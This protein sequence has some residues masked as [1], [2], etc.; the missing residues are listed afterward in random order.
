MGSNLSKNIVIALALAGALGLVVT[1]RVIPYLVDQ[2]SYTDGDQVWHTTRGEGLRYAVW[3]PAE[4]LGE[5]VNTPA[6]ETRPALSGDGRWLV[7]G[8]G[9]QGQNAELYVARMVDGQ[10][11]DAR[12]VAGLNSD[13]DEIAP[14]FGGD[15]LYFASNRPGG[16]GGFDLY[17]A[18]W[19]GERFGPAR[20]L[21][22]SV[23]TASDE[24]DPALHGTW[25]SGGLG[26]TGE[27]L[28]ASNRAGA[29]R[30]DF[31]LF[32]AS[33]D[34]LEGRVIV[35]A[36]T[37]LN[38]PGEEREPGLTA[39]GRTLFF[40]S[41]RDEAGNFDLWKSFR[42]QGTWLA[43]QPL[44]GLNS[45]ASERGPGPSADGFALFF[46]RAAGDAPPDLLRAESAEL[47]RLPARPLGW[48]DLA[49]LAALLLL[50]L[51]AWLS[52]RWE[53]LDI[54]YKCFLVSLLVHLLLMWLMRG[55]HPESEPQALSPG[56]APTFKVRVL[57]DTTT[58]SARRERG[59]ALESARE[60]VE[61]AQAPARQELEQQAPARPTLRRESLA[62]SSAELAQG[63]AAAPLR[64]ARAAASEQ[65]PVPLLAD[66]GPALPLRSG[67]APALEVAVDR[68][69]RTSVAP[70]GAPQQASPS[71]SS[72]VAPEVANPHTP[73]PTSVARV[74]SRE[75]RIT[76]PEPGAPGTAGAVAALHP[77]AS[78]QRGPS[79]AQP[80]AQPGEVAA[81][82]SVGE[83]AASLPEPGSFRGRVEHDRAVAP[84]LA[85]PSADSALR[86]SSEALPTPGAAGLVAQRGASESPAAPSFRPTRQA[87]ARRTSGV[88]GPRLEAPAAAR[89]ARATSAPARALDLPTPTGFE[90]PMR[91]GR[92]RAD[93][94]RADR[95]RTGP[96]GDA[97][98]SR[99]S[100]PLR[101]S[102]ASAA[103][104]ERVPDQPRPSQVALEV[105][106]PPREVALP[107]SPRPLE[108]TPYRS[109]FGSEKQVALETFGGGVDTERAVLEGLKYLAAHQR[110]AGHWASARDRDAKYH[111][112][113]VG[114]TALCLLAFLAAGHTPDSDTQFSGTARRA[115]DY[116]LGTQLRRNGHFGDTASYGHGIATYA[117]AE[118][119]ALTRSPS[120]RVPLERAVARILSQQIPDGYRGGERLEGG[121]GYYYG[122]GSTY[123]SWPRVSIT[124]W[125]VM[126][127]EAA[128]LGGI[129]VDEEALLAAGRFIAGS[130]DAHLGALRYSHDPQRLGSGYPTLPGSTPAGL[131]A[132]SLL[133]QDLSED[134]FRAPRE[135]VMRRAPRGWRYEGE[136]AFVERAAANVYFL[137]YGSL[138]M[139]R[140]GGSDWR[141]W[142]VALKETLL[143]SQQQDGSWRPLGVYARYAGDTREDSV[144]TTA[145]CVLSLEVYYRYF[146][147]L[148]ERE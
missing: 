30:G 5:E 39:D 64:V 111:D 60:V 13:S 52:K 28:F 131:F 27:L 40:A 117:L 137:Y 12:A 138:A 82:R 44:V 14:A 33:F 135:Y 85:Q 43:P 18:T 50:A 37:Q 8:V 70:V 78:P 106:R 20:R 69:E 80:G 51:L 110:E 136:E 7:F 89:V 61:L 84:G 88:E 103:A 65:L 123:D 91:A 93:R 17:S 99:P 121:W 41:D 104:A 66:A 147:P 22:E 42:E 101:A 90:A 114:N 113:R 96:P 119:Y 102:V 141:R 3:K 75:S 128:R 134:R 86:G 49:L 77:Q 76:R 109:R 105:E 79:V 53:H 15:A 19:D 62:R 67:A 54:I 16:A 2:A 81:L 133:G 74:E 45:E 68:G 63:P 71:R 130:W 57:R 87:P 11:V 143:P 122:D 142:N 107:D 29:G 132:L 21:S 148:L 129:E 92:E 23:N 35:E 140:A 120:L 6:R 24:V 124:S 34:D 98:T 144:F 95:E 56:R 97:S 25:D 115:V 46:E 38:S 58:L 116:L 10:P 118:C 4:L 47:F 55:V 94:E 126:A 1:R 146:T 112:V 100:A 139:L 31:D 145:M 48:A 125:Q 108:A 72:A 59:G 73:G 26:G 36:L 83:S 32:S 9:E 127:L